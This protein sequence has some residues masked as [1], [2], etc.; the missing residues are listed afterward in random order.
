MGKEKLPAIH[1]YPGDWLRDGISGCSLAAQGLWLR[2]MFVAH[3]APNYGEMF[4]SDL[5]P[6]KAAIAR[7]CGCSVEEFDALFLELLEAEIPSVENGIVVSRRMVRDGKLRAVRAK[8]GR[9][10]GKQNGKQSRSKTKANGEAKREQNTEIEIEND[11]D[12][13]IDFFEEFWRVFPTGRKRDKAAARKAWVTAIT[14]WNPQGII[15]A[16]IDYAA[17]D[18]GRGEYVK[19][20]SSWLNGECWADDRDAWK[21]KGSPRGSPMFDRDDPYGNNA[22]G[23]AFLESLKQ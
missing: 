1:L 9:K 21:A 12:N 10:G 5:L 13:E 6:A 19:M 11:P 22:A 2:M 20:P 3:D 23:D 16:A 8:A 14:K 15:A 7:R 4:A 18:Q 17:S